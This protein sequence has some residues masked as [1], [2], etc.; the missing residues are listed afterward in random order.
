MQAKVFKE[1]LLIKHLENNIIPVLMATVS[2]KGFTSNFDQVI[3]NMRK[4]ALKISKPVD[5]FRKFQLRCNLKDQDVQQ[6]TGLKKYTGDYKENSTFEKRDICLL[7][8][9]FQLTPEESKQMHDVCDTRISKESYIFDCVYDFYINN[10][11]AYASRKDNIL[12]F[13]QCMNFASQ[14]IQKKLMTR[15]GF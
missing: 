4:S 2:R 10:Y 6:I 3:H 12:E 15:S 1:D 9:C 14:Y 5:L 8:I 13:N 7:S 11:K